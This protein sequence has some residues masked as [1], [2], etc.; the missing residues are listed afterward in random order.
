VRHAAAEIPLIQILFFRNFFALFFIGFLV[1]RIGFLAL[2]SDRHR[3]HLARALV[4]LTAMY[5]MVYSFSHLKLTEATLLKATAPIM[6]PLIA[7]FLLKEHLAKLTW[8]AI[9]LAFTGVFVVIAPSGLN[10]SANIGFFAGLG[11]AILASLAKVIIRKLGT[12]EPSE[13]IVF[14]FALYGTVITAPLCYLFWEEMNSVIWGLVFLCA[15]AA[16]AGQMLVTK[17][18]TVAKAGRIGMFSYVSMPI[19]GILGWFIWSESLSLSLLIGSAM[20]I[21][22]GYLNYREFQSTLAKASLPK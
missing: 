17:A 6:I 16:S 7:W 9:F 22:A 13:V 2:K 18:Y 19:A 5:L 20:I 1:S 12:T 4:G 15:L 21:I 10:L 8:I 14:Y 3:L 11:S